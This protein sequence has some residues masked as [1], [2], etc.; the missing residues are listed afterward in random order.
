MIPW[1]TIVSYTS[2]P[3]VYNDWAL[4]DVAVSL[5]TCLLFSPTLLLLR[6]YLP[7]FWCNNRETVCS[8]RI[9]AELTRAW[10]NTDRL[11]LFHTLSRRSDRLEIMLDGETV[12]WMKLNTGK[13]WRHSD[14]LSLRR[15]LYGSP[16]PFCRLLTV[17][18]D[19]EVTS[20]DTSRNWGYCSSECNTAVFIEPSLSNFRIC[21]NRVRPSAIK[22]SPKELVKLNSFFDIIFQN[23]LSLLFPHHFSRSTTFQK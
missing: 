17:L 14:C 7:L 19:I 18:F 21:I 3:V 5:Q 2:K 23:L 15:R 4:T 10:R 1:V 9:G 13:G 12:E 20:G 11:S 16:L 6:W 22:L 8:R